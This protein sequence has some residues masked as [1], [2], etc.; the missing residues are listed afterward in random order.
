[1]FREVVMRNSMTT[2]DVAAHVLCRRPRGTGDTPVLWKLP[3]P[4]RGLQ[5]LSSCPRPSWI[6]HFDRPE[7]SGG[8][9]CESSVLFRGRSEVRHNSASMLI[10]FG[11]DAGIGPV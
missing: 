4:A 6:G 3:P 2:S 10:G 7:K 5:N 8:R 11:H 1:M 9:P